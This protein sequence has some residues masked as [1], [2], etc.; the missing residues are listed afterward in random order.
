M[1]LLAAFRRATSCGPPLAVVATQLVARRALGAEAGG[2]T[3]EAERRR[4]ANRLLYRAKQR[5]FLELDLLVGRWAQAAVPSMPL[6]KLRDLHVVLEM[7]NPDLYKWLTSQE[8]AP[9]EMLQNAAYRQ[10]REHVT[11]Y[12]TTHLDARAK[13]DSGAEWVRG[14]SD[15]GLQLDGNFSNQSSPASKE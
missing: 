13:A 6:E 5:G 11:T 15:T 9:Q 1:A 3:A 14:W 2:A 8:E 12:F 4:L 7:E 10:L